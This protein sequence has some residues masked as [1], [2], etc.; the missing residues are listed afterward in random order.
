[1]LLECVNVEDIFISDQWEENDQ[2]WYED[3]I[4]G[5]KFKYMN[6]KSATRNFSENCA[7]QM[8]V[9]QIPD[10][11]LKENYWKTL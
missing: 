6:W 2:I 9:V 1:M 11:N 4:S 5:E 7:N 8:N 10:A 3:P